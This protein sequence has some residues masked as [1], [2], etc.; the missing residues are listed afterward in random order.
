[1]QALS[2]VHLS[3][4]R[5]RHLA[6]SSLTSA[7][8]RHM[9][10]DE[11]EQ[12]SKDGISS[13]GS[14]KNC[15]N[16]RPKRQSKTRH[17]ADCVTST[18]STLSSISYPSECLRTTRRAE[19]STRNE[20]LRHCPPDRIQGPHNLATPG[21]SDGVK[22]ECTRVIQA[23]SPVHRSM[24]RTRHLPVLSRGSPLHSQR[25]DPEKEQS[26]RKWG[27]PAVVVLSQ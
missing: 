27:E 16:A 5:T 21:E 20:N 6:I 7:P 14:D 15:F 2:P 8:Q 22:G 4:K 10:I 9:D 19:S 11:K 24:K 18:A 17:V 23:L 12:S 25:L 13:V 3:M 1:M 26:R